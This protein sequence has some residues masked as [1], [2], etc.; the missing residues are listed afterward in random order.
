MMGYVIRLASENDCDILSRLKRDIWETSYRG[1][2][3]DDKIDN[4]DFDKNRNSFLKIV[5]NPD[6]ELYVVEDEGKL[7]GY[8]DFG[9]PFRPFGEYKQE[10]GLLYVLKQYQGK[11]IGRELFNLAFDKIKQNGY[12]EFFI[13]CN[14]YNLAA[15]SFYEKMGGKI[16]HVDEDNEDK[17]IPQVKYLYKIK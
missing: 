12:D 1:I 13:S 10:I 9:V 17:S 3:P 4:F 16:I 2:Y 6:I 11:G 15:R 14:K 7:I 5:Y 8:M